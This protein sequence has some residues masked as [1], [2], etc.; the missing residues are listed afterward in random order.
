V[1]CLLDARDPLST[2]SVVQRQTET[3]TETARRN[4]TPT[5]ADDNAMRN[6]TAT[7]TEMKQRDEATTGEAQAAKN[8]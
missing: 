1:N 6:E 5:A 7:A 3:E 2:S 4:T 8:G